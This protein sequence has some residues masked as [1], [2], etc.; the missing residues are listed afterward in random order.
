M[1]MRTKLV[2]HYRPFTSHS[3]RRDAG[4]YTDIKPTNKTAKIE[5]DVC[6]P[7]VEQILTL[8]H[9]F[10]HHIF[11]LLCQ[12]EFQPT[13]KR[14]VMRNDND[15]LK[16]SWK[17]EFGTWQKNNKVTK[18]QKEEIICT[19]VERAVKRILKKELP[20]EFK[21]KFFPDSK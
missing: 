9:E 11:D 3:E 14:I 1:G 6:E 15:E 16:E 10:T 2:I 17:A 20:P 19:K 12:Y 4:Y 18:E 5:V 21:R 13:Q 7:S 8:Y